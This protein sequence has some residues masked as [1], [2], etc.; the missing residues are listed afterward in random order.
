MVHAATTAVG[1]AALAIFARQ[2]MPVRTSQSSQDFGL[3]VCARRGMREA[4]DLLRPADRDRDPA[5]PVP[6]LAV[7]IF[8]GPPQRPLRKQDGIVLKV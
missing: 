3:R 6:R 7:M 8:A 2:A 4:V 1:S 5:G